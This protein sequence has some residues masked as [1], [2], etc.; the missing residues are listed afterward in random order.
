MTSIRGIPGFQ[1]P[2]E[3]GSWSTGWM[4]DRSRHNFRIDYMAGYRRLE[5][6]VYEAVHWAV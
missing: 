4:V 2:R 6:E 3:T 5:I 1:D